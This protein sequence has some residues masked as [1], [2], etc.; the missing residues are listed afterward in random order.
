LLKGDD[1][2][3]RKDLAGRWYNAIFSRYSVRAYDGRSVSSDI[4]CEIGQLLDG[5]SP[6]CKGARAVLL[7]E[8]SSEILSGFM[9]IVGRIRGADLVLVLIGDASYPDHEVAVGFLGEGIILHATSLRLGTCWVSG[10]YSRKAVEARIKLRDSEKVMAVSPIG[11]AKRSGQR[12][13]ERAME[14][15]R[16]LHKRKPLESLVRGLPMEDWPS[17]YREIL[18][19]ARLAPSAVNRQPWRFTVESDRIL[20]SAARFEL[21]PMAARKL[22]CG[23]AML[24]LEA[25]AGAT[26]IQ[27]EWNLLSNPPGIAEYVI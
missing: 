3:I 24:H 23:I 26:G 2:I 12:V 19:S 11:F 17:G 7:E 22:D 15:P 16:V 20:V 4:R 8:G 14:A 5:F 1:V 27:G 13:G 9:G 10:T 25:A 18:E 21:L 6:M